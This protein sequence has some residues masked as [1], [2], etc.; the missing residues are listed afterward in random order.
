MARAV[1]GGEDCGGRECRGWWQELRWASAVGGGERCK[2]CRQCEC[3]GGRTL[4]LRRA[5]APV[6]IG[7]APFVAFSAAI[8]SAP[9]GEPFAM[10]SSLVSM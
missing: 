5:R 3:G 10:A 7:A 4:E 8:Q 6:S 9:A 2:R 1:V